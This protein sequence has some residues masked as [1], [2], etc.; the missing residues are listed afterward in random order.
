MSDN[1][2][3]PDSEANPSITSC[4]NC[5]APM[6]RELRFCRNCGFR[7]GEGSAEY[8]ET[9]R[10]QDARQGVSSRNNAAGQDPFATPYGLSGGPMSPVGGGVVGKRRKRI[11]GM[12]WMFL[13]LLFFFIAAAIFTSVV[14]PIRRGLNP[15][16]SFPSTSRAYVGVNSFDTGDGG[17]TFDN[18]E[19][20]GSPADKAGLVGGDLITAFDGHA[21][22]TDDEIMDLLGLTPIGKT[23]DVV[24]IRDGEQ[25]TTKLTTISKAEFDR[26]VGEFRNRPQGK[27]QFGY[28]DDETERVPIPGTKIFGVRLDEILQSRPADLAG[29]KKGDIVTE[30]D[31]IP[32]RTP[33]ELLSRIRR[34]L[35]YSTVKVVVA[36]GTE[37]LEI[38]VKMGKL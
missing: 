37:Q 29:I 6:P 32:I 11:S 16:I 33:E 31:G 27:G 20:P 36:R 2:F 34:A 23:V 19:P 30:F 3:M 15:Q 14:T 26:L 9:V 17:V 8:T 4:L 35:P 7:L 22:H 25:K 1:A 13:G 21:V 28:D 18:V 12:T 24:F 38:P 10:F 5:H